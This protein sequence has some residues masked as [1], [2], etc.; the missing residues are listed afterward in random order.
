MNEELSPIE[1][2]RAQWKPNKKRI[3]ALKAAIR[4]AECAGLWLRRTV[5]YELLF[6]EMRPPRHLPIK[7]LDT[8]VEK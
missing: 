8:E 5:L 2:Y 4:R 1:H 7:N 3:A 6:S